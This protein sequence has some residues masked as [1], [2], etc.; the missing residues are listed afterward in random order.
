MVPVRPMGSSRSAFPGPRSITAPRRRRS[1]RR[2]VQRVV[3]EVR[4]RLAGSLCSVVYNA[5]SAGH[6]SP[7]YFRRGKFCMLRKGGWIGALAALLL[8]AVPGWKGAAA[9]PRGGA[10]IMVYAAAS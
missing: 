10:E 9:E 3:L 4:L 7:F 2:A 8:A 1:R 6:R 5:A